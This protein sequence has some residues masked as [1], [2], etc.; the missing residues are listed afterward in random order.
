MANIVVFPD[1]TQTVDAVYTNFSQLL[2]KAKCIHKI[3]ISILL[4]LQN[5]TSE[6]LVVLLLYFTLS[7]SFLDRMFS[8]E[9]YAAVAL[10]VSHQLYCRKFIEWHSKWD[11]EWMNDSSYGRNLGVERCN[12]S[13]FMLTSRKW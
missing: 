12:T 9:N 10:P 8:L 11:D 13:T 1:T 4:R 2:N 7:S 6:T 5:W 3:T